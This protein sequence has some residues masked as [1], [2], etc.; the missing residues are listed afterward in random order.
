MKIEQ[1]KKYK[2][3]SGEIIEIVAHN[4]L[5]IFFD[6]DGYRYN[7]DGK[8]DGMGHYGFNLINEVE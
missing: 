3:E 4:K 1:G 6:N 8:C 2:N 7:P 5:E